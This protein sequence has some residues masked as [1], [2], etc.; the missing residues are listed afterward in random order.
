MAKIHINVK[1]IVDI[2]GN[3]KV[4]LKITGM[5]QKYNLPDEYL[6][7]YPCVYQESYTDQRV[8]FR[9]CNTIMDHFPLC[10][11]RSSG[12]PAVNHDP[13]DAEKLIAL[14]QAAGERLHKINQKIALTRAMYAGESEILI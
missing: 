6:S 14:I 1:K 5:E 9:D 13:E 10:D 8:F 11:S 3:K 7:G 4:Q 2:D 12:C